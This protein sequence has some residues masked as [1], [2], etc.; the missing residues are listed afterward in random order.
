MSIGRFEDLRLFA[1]AIVLL[2][3][4]MLCLGVTVNSTEGLAATCV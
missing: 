3:F 1:P 2:E 4:V